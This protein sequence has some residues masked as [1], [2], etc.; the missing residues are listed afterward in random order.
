MSRASL[1]LVYIVSLFA[2][3]SFSVTSVCD[4][5]VRE[6]KTNKNKDAK[7]SLEGTWQVIKHIDTSGKPTPDDEISEFTFEFKGTKLTKRV[8][9][10]TPGTW[11]YFK[12][13]GTKSPMWMDFTHPRFEKLKYL[14]IYRFTE[15]RLEICMAAEYEEKPTFRPSEFKASE[16]S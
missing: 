15:D 5:W 16:K 14:A 11:A 13:D 1:L 7:K 6:E 4:G 9:K 2:S 3:G 10:G 12:A 8:T